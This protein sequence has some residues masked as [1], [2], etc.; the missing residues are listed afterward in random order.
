[1]RDF[2]RA[3]AV[4]ASA[5][6]V[7]LLLFLLLFGRAFMGGVRPQPLSRDEITAKAIEFA[8]AE[9]WS[10]SGQ[11]TRTVVVEGD[12]AEAVRSSG[13]QVVDR[14]ALPDPLWETEIITN[15]RSISRMFSLENPPD[16]LLSI[17]MTPRG[18]VVEY[19]EVSSPI[20]AQS[21]QT[22]DPTRIPPPREFTPK[23]LYE[24]LPEDALT[25]PG[26]ERARVLETARSFFERHGIRLDAAPTSLT[27]K[28]GLNKK[29]I[30]YLTWDS[31]GPAG[32]TDETHVIVASDRVAAYDHDLRSATSP[33]ESWRDIVTQGVGVATGLVYFLDMALVAVILAIKLRQREVNLR[34]AVTIASAYGILFALFDFGMAGLNLSTL[35]TWAGNLT[36]WI[37][38]L[39]TLIIIPAITITGTLTVSAAWAVGESEGYAT[40]P[41]QMMR[42]ISAVMRGRLLQR[43]VAVSIALGYL[44]A[45]AALGAATLVGLV[46]PPSAQPS[47]AP[48]NALNSWPVF[49][50]PL[51]VGLLS[52]IST[53]L[54]V[55]MF[56]MT[57]VKRLTRRTWL[58]IVVGTISMAVQLAG[59]S[60]IPMDYIW[61]LGTTCVFCLGLTI[62]FVRSGPLASLTATF[63]FLDLILAYP[64]MLTG[65]I[66]HAASGAWAFLL[67]LVPAGVAAYGAWRPREVDQT[68]AIPAHVR[69]VMERLRIG[70]EF[71]VA[72]RVQLGLLPS[73]SPAVEGLDVAGLCV[74]ANEVGGDYY[75]YFLLEDGRLAIAVGD[76]SGK[77]V[78]AAIYMTLTKSYMVTQSSRASEP[79]RLL[80]RVNDHLKRNL[81][82]GSFVTMAFAVLDVGLRRLTYVR[83]G[84]NSPLLVRA[85]GEGDFLTAPG[86]ALGATGSRIFESIT[87]AET[88]DLRR[89]DLILLY[90][91]GVT[92]A[93]NLQGLEYGEERLALLATS[94][95]RSG[96]TAAAVIDAILKE[97]RTFSGRAPQHDDIT[98][99]AIRVLELPG[100]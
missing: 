67:G 74:P 65:N 18:E 21:I 97:V 92:E 47:T 64:L 56:V 54:T 94:L 10:N 61:S 33:R 70:E 29:R 51:L 6:V 76:V 23:K 9:G 68:E 25:V 39:P 77:G 90:T 5:A 88:I 53:T 52:S 99:V 83:A 59:Y 49:L 35:M 79:V 71:E 28:E 58:T 98:I 8:A 19:V 12:D 36:M 57:Y 50:F 62:L 82:R 37:S 81:A 63:V 45:F 78:G 38:L 30:A 17:Q 16:P 43:D 2:I 100:S 32:T 93:M 7:G 1:M 41:Q 84:H 3:N 55:G 80:A 48:L 26:E 85:N 27:V 15:P 86:V 34:A 11:I 72:R 89:G 69:R 96:S 13:G 44:V 87:K 24:V 22:G 60:A 40:W 73:E 46:A 42:P 4:L 20:A 95:G 14:E 66:G 31:P 91:D 75:D